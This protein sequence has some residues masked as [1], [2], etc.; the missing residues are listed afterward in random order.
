MS[1]VIASSSACGISGCCGC[2]G[3]GVAGVLETVGGFSS[4][5]IRC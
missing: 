4:T 2:E 3:I 5:P 1:S